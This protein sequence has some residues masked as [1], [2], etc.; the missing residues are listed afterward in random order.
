MCRIFGVGVDKQPKSDWEVMST[1]SSADV[2]LNKDRVA[3]KPHRRA[4]LV[5]KP[6]GS[7]YLDNIERELRSVLYEGI[8]ATKTSFNIKDD[9][10]GTRWVVLEDGNFD[11]LVSSVFTVGNA[12]VSNGGSKDLLAAVFLYHY[13]VNTRE[14]L[15]AA[16][17]NVYWIYTYRRK[18]FYPFVP[19]GAQE[20]DRPAELHLAKVMKKIGLHVDAS[21]EDWY[22]LWGIPF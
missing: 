10:Y 22:G 9:Q 21:L 13:K 17:S 20:R 6:N 8:G 16:G 12:I 4:G 2:R 7:P 15:G 11:D 19:S 18:A 14:K 1:L 5:Y 3:A